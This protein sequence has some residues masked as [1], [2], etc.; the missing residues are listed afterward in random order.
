MEQY[1]FVRY[2]EIIP[3]LDRVDEIYACVCLRWATKN[4]ADHP[5]QYGSAKCEKIEIDGGRRGEGGRE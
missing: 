5:F 2:F 1:A 4:G 3:P